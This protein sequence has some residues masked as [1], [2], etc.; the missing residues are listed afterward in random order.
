MLMST[1]SRTVLLLLFFVALVSAS[2]ARAQQTLLQKLL[3]DNRYALAVQNG[4]MTGSGS[5]FLRKLLSQAQFVAIGEEHGTR[6]K[7]STP[8]PSKPV[9]S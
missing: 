8:W 9:P 2:A 4:E 1:S 7:D 5:T 6:L 3:R